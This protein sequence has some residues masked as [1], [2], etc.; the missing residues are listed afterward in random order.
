MPLGWSSATTPG[1]YRYVRGDRQS[2]ACSAKQG[3][4][5]LPQPTPE[6]SLA[7]SLQLI[8]DAGVI[9]LREVVIV[10]VVV[11]AKWKVI[12]PPDGGAPPSSSSPIRRARQRARSQ[13]LSP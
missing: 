7:R 9:A 3:E 10:V 5:P 2:G 6:L 13:F 4:T 12:E 11:I 1:L 8:V